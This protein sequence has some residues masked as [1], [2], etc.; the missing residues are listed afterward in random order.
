MAILLINNADKQQF[1]KIQAELYNDFLKGINSY[2]AT[3]DKDFSLLLNHK[4]EKR[5]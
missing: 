2:P 4:K 1:S 5:R 3:Y